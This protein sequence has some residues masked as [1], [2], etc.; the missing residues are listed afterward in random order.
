MII[1]F[2]ETPD[3]QL[4]QKKIFFG[5]KGGDNKIKNPK[6]KTKRKERPNPFHPYFWE[7]RLLQNKET[8]EESFAFLV[9]EL[10]L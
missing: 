7:K 2:F 1:L 10:N 9:K 4:K 5:F 8:L 3:G 6:F